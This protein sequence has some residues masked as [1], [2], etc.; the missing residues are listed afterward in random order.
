MRKL[1][2]DT[3]FN[4]VDPDT[5]HPNEVLAIVFH[6]TA[7]ILYLMYAVWG[8]VSVALNLGDFLGEDSHDFS[9]F[10]Y[11]L[12]PVPALLAGIG[13]LHFPK[14]GRME[15]FAASAL[16]GF[17]CIFL[18]IGLVGAIQHPEFP[19][20]WQNLILNTTHVVLPIMRV[21]FVFRT[22]V[23]EAYRKRSR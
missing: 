3:V 16:V 22:L 15:M 12:V 14:W 11:F 5:M 7:V 6:R 17:I 23:W 8:L 2:T 20:L 1:L 19:R 13:A 18:V 4:K 9:D 21:G 10:F